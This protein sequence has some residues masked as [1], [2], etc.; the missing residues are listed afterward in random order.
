MVNDGLLRQLFLDVVNLRQEWFLEVPLCVFQ[1]APQYVFLE[2]DQECVFLIGC[3]V[4]LH[5][6][7]QGLSLDTCDCP[8]CVQCLLVCSGEEYFGY[9]LAL[10][11]ERI[12]GLDSFLEVLVWL[13]SVVIGFETLV[14]MSY[15]YS[16]FLKNIQEIN[17]SIK[18]VLY[19]FI[20]SIV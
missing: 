6:H 1:K 10:C 5:P 2:Q 3:N 17:L 20:V 14:K 11:D 8:E 19:K 13:V 15:C 9:V 12:Y 4:L 18:Y 7:H 16:H